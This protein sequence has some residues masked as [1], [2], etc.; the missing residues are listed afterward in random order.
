MFG[1]NIG[2][3]A[4]LKAFLSGIGLKIVIAFIPPVA[5]A[6]L[7]FVMTLMEVRTHNPQNFGMVL[8]LGLTG[9]A[10]GSLVVIWLILSVVPPLRRTVEVTEHLAQ[11]NLE[12]TTGCEGRRDE[13][14]ELA[15]ALEVFRRNA[16]E[17]IA[18]EQRAEAE[19]L[20]AAVEKREALDRVATGFEASVKSVVD[21]F[22][23]ASAELKS[24]ALAMS[25]TAEQTTRQAESALGAS[26]RAA[27]EV[28]G[29]ADAAEHLSGSIARIAGQ[30]SEAAQIAT[31]A[32]EQ[33][34]A[35]DSIIQ[36]LSEAANRI[37]EVVN[38]INDI[39]GQTNLLA[40]NATIEAARAGEAGKG[41]AVVAGEV[42]TLAS[43]TSRATG[44][45]GGQVV[46][47]QASTEQAVGAIRQITATIGRI[48][49][50][51]AAI[52]VAV[53]EQGRATHGIASSAEAAAADTGNVS[54]AIGDVTQAAASAGRSAHSVLGAAEHIAHQS[55]TLGGEV[56]RFIAGIR[57]G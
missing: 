19:K 4:L 6:W 45:I 51:S 18:L 9:I 50:I 10:L 1:G 22:A 11:G 8:G 23:S 31:G 12:E 54:H 40:L 53:D 3:G 32:V 48:S 57:A 52:A 46:A 24:T 42:K 29:V 34:R 25:G 28:R 17:K 30:V 7:F 15:R 55:E 37:G 38:L 26:G 44:E 49:D 5:L 2:F 43:Q 27:E 56:S 39:A 21:G 20:R 47:I 16:T 36:G 14:G 35:T 33:A 41:F 13:I